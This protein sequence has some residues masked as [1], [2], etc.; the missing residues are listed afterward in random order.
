MRG[1]HKIGGDLLKKTGEKGGLPVNNVVDPI[2]DD[3]VER[4][5]RVHKKENPALPAGDG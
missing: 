2:M 4:L 5:G 1:L 3:R